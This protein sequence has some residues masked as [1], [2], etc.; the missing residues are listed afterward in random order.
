MKGAGEKDALFDAVLD[1]AREESTAAGAG[2]ELYERRGTSV[3][4]VEDDEGRRVLESKERGF[5]L[6]LYRGGRVGFAASGP[7]S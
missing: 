5:A 1:K 6:R 7:E 3:E 4:I 2:A